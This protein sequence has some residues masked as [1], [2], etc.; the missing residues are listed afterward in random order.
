MAII[1]IPDGLPL[2]KAHR[3]H[4]S[5]DIWGFGTVGVAQ[6]WGGRL[7]TL[8]AATCSFTEAP[9]TQQASGVTSNKAVITHDCEAKDLPFGCSR[10]QQCRTQPWQGL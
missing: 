8:D 2:E 6:A 3:L 5:C 9:S 10:R 7:G 4:H 1:T